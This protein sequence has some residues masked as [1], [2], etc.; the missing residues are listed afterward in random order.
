MGVGYLLASLKGR[1]CRL[2]SKLLKAVLTIVGAICFPEQI[3]TLFTSD[4]AVIASGGVYLLMIFS[5]SGNIIVGNAIRGSG[6]TKWMLYTQLFG[7]VWIV[8]VASVLV[9][10]CKL[11]ILG[12]FLAVMADEGVRALINLWKYFRIVKRWKFD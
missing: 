4:Q 1:I 5:K 7:T 10:V 12:V 3:L 2:E 6:N 8:C 11:G 9:F